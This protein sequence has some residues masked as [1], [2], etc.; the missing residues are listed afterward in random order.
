M[1]GLARRS[2]LLLRQAIDR[3][4]QEIRK[5]AE[6]ILSREDAVRAHYRT[7]RDRR[8]TAARIRYHGDYHLGQVLYTG[9]DFVIIDFEGEPARPLSERRLKVP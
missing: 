2:L 9:R 4:P 6:D 8:I 5:D 1:L 7:I 3:L